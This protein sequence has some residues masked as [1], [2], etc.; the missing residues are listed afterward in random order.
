MQIQRVLVPAAFDDTSKTAV[1]V[2]ACRR[3]S[4]VGQT[5]VRGDHMRAVQIVVARSRSPYGLG[6]G[7]AR[8]HG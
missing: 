5:T 1:P 3:V 4:R 6:G 7:A 8:I 2:A